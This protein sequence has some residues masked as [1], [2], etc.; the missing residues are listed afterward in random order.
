MPKIFS[1]PLLLLVGF[2]CAFV[3]LLPLWHFLSS[4]P[5]TYNIQRIAEILLVSGAA[6]LLI[7]SAKQRTQWIRT[8]RHLPELGR[9]G[10]VIFFGL[11]VVSTLQAE[12]PR[13]AFLELGLFALLFIF[14]LAISSAVIL[15]ETAVTAKLIWLVFCAIALYSIAFYINIFRPF[16]NNLLAPGFSN[17]RLLAQFQAWTLPLVTLPLFFL[18]KTDRALRVMVY[19]FAALWWGIAFFN[20]AKGLAVALVFSGLLILMLMKDSGSRQWL[21]LQVKVVLLGLAIYLALSLVTTQGGYLTKLEDSYG[22]RL[23]L[24]R[25]SL[26][27][28]LQHPILG[29][30][31]LHLS[32]HVNGLG[33]HPHNSLLQIAA[34]WG[35]PA[36]LTILLLFVWGGWAWLKQSMAD[37]QPMRIALTFALSTGAIYSLT[38][39]IIVMPLSQIMMALVIGL[40][41]GIYQHKSAINSSVSISSHWFLII[42]IALILIRFNSVLFPE[43][44]HLSRD[45]FVWIATHSQEGHIRLY[46]RFWQQGW[47]Q[48]L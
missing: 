9:L 40:I 1:S 34:E 26:H 2:F 13:F 20:S 31:P 38:S 3:S 21:L 28:I 5:S 19:L 33:A 47:F 29:I 23:T 44:L 39:G 24:W 36:T 18:A 12:L 41:L 22:S 6:L 43:V 30:G 48:R 25:E 11:G 35:I 15:D 7:L 17:L 46:P 4:N 27:Y 45:E 10:I 8:F 16:S 42:A 37:Q 32:N 14:A